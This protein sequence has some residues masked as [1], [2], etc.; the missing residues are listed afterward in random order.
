VE[1]VADVS[2]WQDEAY[3]WAQAGLPVVE[4]PQTLNRLVPATAKFYEGIMAGKIRHD[5]DGAIQR[6]IDNCILKMDSRGGSRLTKDYRNPRLK[7][8][9]AI[10]TLLAFDRCSSGKLE[11]VPQFFG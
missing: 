7:I 1:L 9:L 2:F 4:Y 10:A 11:P 6:H 8:D 5:G 3:Q